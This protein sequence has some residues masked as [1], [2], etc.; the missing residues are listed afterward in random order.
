MKNTILTLFAFLFLSQNY[1]QKIEDLGSPKPFSIGLKGTIYKYTVPKFFKSGNE[2]DYKPE[3]EQTTPLG[4]V[5]TQSLNISERNLT[6]P[7]PGIP[8]DMKIFAIIYTGNFEIRD[9]GEYLFV[10]KSDDGSRLWIDGK[11]IINNDGMHKFTTKAAKPVLSKGFHSIKV[12]YFQGFPDRMGLQLLMRHTKDTLPPKPFDL[13]TYEK[14][15]NDIIQSEKT[16]KG[17]KAKIED[18]FLFDV[19]KYAL[20]PEAD[21]WILAMA[22]LLIFNPQSKV[23]IEGHTDNIGSA[24]ANKKL[25]EN[26]AK[27]VMAALKK[28]NVPE[29]IQFEVKGLGFSQPISPNDTEGGRALNRRVEVVIESF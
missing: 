18:K 25:S 1:A 12:W 26:R 29:S 14:E 6:V 7:F 21:E 4:Y 15:I 13:S 20:K 10:L 27:A 22:R 17:I 16:D 8:E 19:N 5:Y 9:S 11:E 24:A 3:I 23:I 2:W 28:M